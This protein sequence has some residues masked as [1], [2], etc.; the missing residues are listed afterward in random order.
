MRLP[1]LAV[2]CSALLFSGC[3]K[4]KSEQKTATLLKASD[5][6]RDDLYKQVNYLASVDSM[7]AK[8]DL[9]F[10]D[11]SYAE[12]GS[13]DLY[14]SA[15]GDVVVQRPA[16]IRLKVE[17][18]IIGTDVAQMTSDGTRFRVAIL[19]DGGSGR[20]KKF[21]LGS[22]AVDYS[23]LQKR[24]SELVKNDPTKIS[25]SVNAFA[26]MRPQHFTEALLVRPIDEAKFLYLQS[27]AVQEEVDFKQYKRKNPL[28]WVLRSYYFLDEFERNADGG[29]R[30]VRRFWFDRVGGALLS[31]QQIFDP[32]GEIESDIVYG[33]RGPTTED[34]SMFLP[35]EIQV[36]RPKE[37][38]KITLKYQAPSQVKI[39]RKIPASAFVLENEWNLEVLDL[40]QKLVELRNGGIDNA[41]PIIEAR[42]NN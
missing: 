42:R 21:V 26:N 18:P 17:V 1:V 6:T 3:I 23:V 8:M 34:G 20:N 25:K 33:K 40:D 29:M 41:N 36:T 30:I 24:V 11:N 19:Q 37:K 31:R 32:A 22:N 4:P 35:L 9:I 28:G 12:F 38:Y 5:A 15:D 10:E 13:S 2:F 39:G 14:R 7:R 16:N 27:T